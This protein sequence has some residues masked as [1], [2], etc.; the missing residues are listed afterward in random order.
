[1]GSGNYFSE[2]RFET[3]SKAIKNRFLAE[4]VFWMRMSG[5][6]PM[7]PCMSS[8]YS[9]QLSYTLT[10]EFIISYLFGFVNP[11]F[12]FFSFFFS[13]LCPHDKPEF[14]GMIER[15]SEGSALRLPPKG[16]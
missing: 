3:N 11:H 1:M 8:R 14:A 9:N 15:H 7:T 6:E 4:T 13:D 2:F 16:Y 5:L 10:T 12:R